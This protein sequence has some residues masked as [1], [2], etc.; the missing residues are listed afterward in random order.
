MMRAC[1]APGAAQAL[2]LFPPC[3]TF[4]ADAHHAEIDPCIRELRDGCI[5]VHGLHGFQLLLRAI[6]TV[7]FQEDLDVESHPATENPDC[8]FIIGLV[9]PKRPS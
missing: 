6:D 1:T 4:L 9:H 7:H 3:R 8:F 5:L 2:L